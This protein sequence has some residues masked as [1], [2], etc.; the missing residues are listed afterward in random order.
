MASEDV[1][2]PSRGL[3]A[4]VAGAAALALVVRLAAAR[5][6]P[7][8][9]DGF[10]HLFA[11]RNLAREMRNVAHPPLYLLLLAACDRIASRP[12]AYRAVSIV[13]GTGSV[14]LI[15]RVLEKLR[16][17]PGVVA[18]TALVAALDPSA[19]VLSCEVRSYA[20]CA[21]FVLAAFLCLLDIVR[22]DRPCPRGRR[23]GF[24]AFS[25][26]ALLSH[27][28]AAFFVAASA[29]APFLAAAASSEG[30]RAMAR[31]SR[32]RWIADAATF[33]PPAAVAAILFATLARTWV[34]SLSHLP[35]YYFRPALESA[36]GFL[37]RAASETFR[38]LWPRP[39]GAPAL[40]AVLLAA[41]GAG[42]FAVAAWRRT[43]GAVPS[44]ERALPAAMLVVLLIVGAAAA[45]AG[46]YPF[47]GAMRHQ[48]LILLFAFLAAAVA[49]DRLW[50]AV[51]WRAGRIAV[52]GLAA[53]AVAVGGASTLVRFSR[54]LPEGFTR[55]VAAF[56]A[57]F[58]GERVVHTDQYG[59]V[60][61]FSE[62]SDWR[63]TF[64]G[65]SAANPE[66]ETYAVERGL[67]R[68]TV[69]AHRD[70][71]TFDFADPSLYRDLA[72]AP[73]PA[74]GC[75]AVFHVRQWFPDLPKTDAAA[76]EARIFAGAR[77]ADW[78]PRRIVVDGNDRF[79]E[80]C[81]E[82]GGA[83]G[84]GAGSDPT[85]LPKPAFA[86]GA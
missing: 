53:V 27:Y 24:A 59:L 38:L 77:A 82:A 68:T 48:F 3:R 51:P 34:H 8:G 37:V 43:P 20:L 85:A 84:G 74:A 54:P 42:L 63:W 31:R 26:L 57:A 2:A 32:S 5:H 19:I 13:A 1:F 73:S 28:A 11:A 72:G 67:Q 69:V 71:W 55:D 86:E 33:A 61:F 12:L 47:G 52:G 65:R 39:F 21:F 14:L 36:T 16:L 56:D 44:S 15:G 50:L 41:A 62:R 70:R 17:S 7:V 64:Q 46:W 40:E 4:A 81:P 25:S 45:L 78:S 49:A 79:V 60:G 6:V 9:Y 76:E 75:V 83:R 80:L 29:L 35:Q 23:V 18:L 22:S 30:R 10:W 58:P 66:I